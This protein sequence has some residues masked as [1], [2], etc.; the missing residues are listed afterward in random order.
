MIT[1]A[2]RFIVPAI[3]CS[4]LAGGIAAAE[5]NTTAPVIRR[6]L[7]TGFNPPQVFKNINLLRNTNLEKGYVRETVN[8]VV[9]NI[10][11]KPQDEYYLLFSTS[12]ISN[13]GGLEVRDKKDAKKPKFVIE[14]TEFVSSRFV[15]VFPG[16]C[17]GRCCGCTPA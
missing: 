11:K 7:P 3:L 2:M 12:I 14:A 4:L 6:V 5:A 10:D 16:L 15:M 9:Q 8:V 13:V 1:A 17:P